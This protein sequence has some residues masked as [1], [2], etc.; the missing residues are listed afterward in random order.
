LEE[1]T[2][3]ATGL[4]ISCNCCFEGTGPKTPIK[5]RI[6]N[7]LTKKNRIAHVCNASFKKLNLPDFFVE[8]PFLF[9]V[10]LAFDNEVFIILFVTFK[11]F[12]KTT[13]INVFKSKRV[14]IK[15]I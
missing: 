15:W 7:M 6:K 1:R 12:R 9:G 2:S 13:I 10:G 8:L 14:C 4:L 5:T 11:I 3:E